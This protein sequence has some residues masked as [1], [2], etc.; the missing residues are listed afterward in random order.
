MRKAHGILGKLFILIWQ[1]A[2]S[3]KRCSCSSGRN[4]RPNTTLT[5]YPISRICWSGQALQMNVK[6]TA[7]RRIK[8]LHQ[9]LYIMTVNSQSRWCSY[10]VGAP[11]IPNRP[12]KCCLFNYKLWK[13]LSRRTIVFQS[14]PILCPGEN[15]TTETATK[16][17]G[18]YR[19]ILLISFRL[20]K[21]KTNCWFVLQNLNSHEIFRKLI[22]LYFQ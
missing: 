13:I 11:R 6:Y 12:F 18:V 14:R 2:Y 19:P 21:M 1:R 8:G 16:Q 3:H 4:K 9:Y 10:F 20:F 7:K 15:Q 5:S 17:Q 22:G